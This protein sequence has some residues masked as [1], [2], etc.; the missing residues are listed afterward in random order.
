MKEICFYT[1]Q[2]FTVHSTSYGKFTINSFK[3]CCYR[4]LCS[5]VK[6]DVCCLFCVKGRSSLFVWCLKLKRFCPL[7]MG[8][9]KILQGCLIKQLQCA[10]CRKIVFIRVKRLQSAGFCPGLPKAGSLLFKKNGQGRKVAYSFISFSITRHF[11]YPEQLGSF[12]PLHF[13]WNKNHL[14]WILT[15]R[16]STLFC[17]DFAIQHSFFEWICHLPFKWH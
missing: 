16:F 4:I 6:I 12:L 13:N 15:W 2:H 3:S 17:Y 7:S 10:F 8:N 14:T 11:G 9:I 5:H 1:L